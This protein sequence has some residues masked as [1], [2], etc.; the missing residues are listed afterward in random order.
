MVRSLPAN[1]VTA[2]P[3]H[4]H[5]LCKAVSRLTAKGSSVRAETPSLRT[6]GTNVQNH[7]QTPTGIDVAQL[8]Q[9]NRRRLFAAVCGSGSVC[10][11]EEEAAGSSGTG[12]P[13]NTRSS[14]DQCHLALGGIVWE[15]Q[16]KSLLDVILDTQVTR[17]SPWQRL[18]FLPLRTAPLSPLNEEGPGAC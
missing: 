11:E 7:N 6:N 15:P 16:S 1:E 4:T 8:S 14:F 12:G 5:H 13:C 17:L 3:F 18:S 2:E 9:P 10:S